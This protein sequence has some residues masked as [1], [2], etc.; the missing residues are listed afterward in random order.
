MVDH[1][2]PDIAPI[3]SR[4]YTGSYQDKIK[5]KPDCNEAEKSKQRW[6][7]ILKYAK[8]CKSLLDYGCGPFALKEHQP[9]DHG[10]T[11]LVGFDVN[12]QTGYYDERVLDEEYDVLCAFHI[13]EHLIEPRRFLERVKHEYLFIILPWI[14][15]FDDEDWGTNSG[16]IFWSGVHHQFFTRNS[17][18]I[19]LKDYEILEE[20]FGDGLIGFPHKP[21]MVVTQALRKKRG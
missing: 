21:E 7:L 3:T 5:D 10:F 18:E 17:L 8:G 13:L 4:D 9:S 6:D 20:N 19:L 15:Y 16:N 14:E 11:K 12:W 2:W 1:T